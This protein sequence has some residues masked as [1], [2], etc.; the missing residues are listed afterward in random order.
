MKESIFLNSCAMT[1]TDPNDSKFINNSP[2]TIAYEKLKVIIAAKNEGKKLDWAN[3][4][5]T[6]WF[7]VFYKSGSGLVFDCADYW[8]TRTFV[9][10]HLCFVSSEKVLESVIEPEVLALYT[11]YIN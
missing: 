3:G 11:A 7:P 5:Q 1:G 10:S 6:K 4:N 2:D 8:D 9:P